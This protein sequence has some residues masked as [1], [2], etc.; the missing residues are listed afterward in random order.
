MKEI[1]PRRVVFFAPSRQMPDLKNAT[2]LIVVLK[3]AP[4]RGY[5]R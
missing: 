4:I 1:D 3:K 2:S 5:Q